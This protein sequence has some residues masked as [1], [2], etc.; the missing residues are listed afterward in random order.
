MTVV[1]TRG[2][3][4]EA[5]TEPAGQP[6]VPID[7][8]SSGAVTQRLNPART[9]PIL[10]AGI[11]AVELVDVRD[12]PYVMLRSPDDQGQARYLRLAPEEWRLARLMDGSRTVARLVAEFARVSGRLAPEQ[13]SRVVAD[14][15][16]SRMLAE[17]PEEA[18]P[19]H[20]LR[21]LL[22]VARGRRMVV[23]DVDP[24]VGFLYRAGGR[25]F[26]TRAVA[27]LMLVVAGAGFG[28][29][30]LTWARGDQSLFQLGGSYAAGAAI[31]L[32]L[33]I[34]AL[35]VH[36]LGHALAARHAGRRVSAGGIF[37]YFGIPS[38]FVDTSDVSLAGRRARI[39][40]TAAGPAA[41]LALAG[42]AQLFGLVV[43][44]VAPWAFA[45]AFVC[46]LNA[47]VNLS[48]FLPF[49]GHHLL[50]EWL[51]I[52]NLRTRG[53]AYVTAR[54]RRRPP[55]WGQL[56][57]E[58]RLVALYGV[59][60]VLW[61]ILALGLAW[62]LWSDRVAG[63]VTGLWWSGGPAR[64]LLVAVVAGLAA[65]AVYLAAGWLARAARRLRH[66]IRERRQDEDLARR[67]DALRRSA[68]G[69]LPEERLVAL[70][71]HATWV[72]PRTGQHIVTAGAPQPAVYV[73][74][75]GALEG[76]R[77]GDPAGT[78]RERR[79]PGGV[80][81]L[82]AAVSGT[83]AALAW[84]TAGTTL[85]AVPSAL[86]A[87]AIG[88]LPGP[89]PVERAEVETL[90]ADTPALDGLPAEERIGLITQARPIV[91][92]PGGPIML[93]AAHAA[94]IV[95]SG[96]VALADGT[97]LRRG[98]MIGPMG[99][100]VP[101]AVA[102]ARTQV[103][104]WTIPAVPG[105]PL[106]LGAAP[107][108]AA[109]EPSASATPRGPLVGPPG[110]PLSDGDD[111]V[112]RR[113]ERRMWALAGFLGLLAITTGV[114]AAVPGPAWAE[115][116][117][118]RALLTAER[119]QVTV[120]LDG[121]AVT[122][123]P[124]DR[125]YV[126]SGGRINVP[127]GASGTLTFRGG[128]A[129]VL[130]P[131]SRAEVGPV[132]TGSAA[133]VLDAGRVLADTASTSGAFGP[134]ALSVRTGGS[135]VANRGA[136]WFAAMHADGAGGGAAAGPLGV[137][138]ISNG[139]VRVDGAAQPATNAALTCGDGVV[140]TPPA[141]TPSDSPSPSDPPVPTLS[142]TPTPSASPS[143]T[144]S[145]SPT[146]SAS[147]T[148]SLSPTTG[149]PTTRPPSTPR[150]RPTTPS[151]PPRTTPPPTPTPSA[152]PSPTPSPLPSGS[153]SPVASPPADTI[154]P[155]PSP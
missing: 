11:D 24:L 143:A 53:L 40:T 102:H 129:L 89:T 13:V 142:A 30:G 127:A 57:R 6:T 140:V 120:T 38:V 107:A 109:A 58:G 10:R 110:P 104:L 132:W 64:L 144:P 9:R 73:V 32:A 70:A 152:T 75:D 54:L 67:L 119:G 98:T 42:A 133:L 63:L 116:P 25:L 106:L 69:R 101:E 52:P 37:L 59:L 90:F 151:A 147:V 34:V 33:H 5:L 128:A 148:P 22:A 47:L 141:G 62:R 15:A 124:G 3:L 82:A 84:H 17:Q 39:A 123:A 49:D 28:L 105:M 44:P 118:D 78:V 19:T 81:G 72:H 21:S 41:G 87:D 97:E 93:P 23:A 65:P 27:L 71:T 48:P 136:A 76:R 79:G 31:L 112:D 35:T 117:A 122:L 80:V 92:E 155:P 26:F 20:P 131:D 103:R 130:C 113:F 153:P 12:T 50:A 18:A 77:P 29:F 114:A 121:R 139:D 95:A 146:P 91:V 150:P 61:L 94:L 137:A 1:E 74:V 7:P 66:R 85:L 8:E 43:P 55:A 108:A 126:A 145:A 2:S 56:D 36:E 60:A 149:A 86:V 88:R 99:Y 51:E 45:L 111:E 14:L 68:L 16:G 46:Y 96:T 115:M 134:L 83:P 135:T 154:T 125:R 100:P 138:T 4:W